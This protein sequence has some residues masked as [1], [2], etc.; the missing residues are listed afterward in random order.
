MSERFDSLDKYYKTLE[1]WDMSAKVLFWLNA[2]LS[3]LVFFLDGNKEIKDILILVFIL[4]TLGYFLV[5][6]YLSI[7]LIPDVEEKRRT[8][9]LTKS[10]NVP[11]DNERTNKYYNNS[12]EP[13]VLKLGAHILENSLNAKKVTHE[14]VKKERVKVSF[15]AVIFV[16][17]MLLRTTDLEFISII[18]QTLFASTLI[19]AWMRLEALNCKNKEIFKGLKNV[20]LLWEKDTAEE[21]VSAFILDYFVKYESAKAYCGVKQSTKIHKKFRDDLS[22]EWEQLKRDLKIELDKPH[23]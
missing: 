4:T 13:S 6:T 15:F 12:L 20:F 16:V 7:S 11:L 8:H 2:F 22:E 9:L 1:N 17:S 10:F 18:A 3:A 5:D 23:K 21:K 19:P 14:M